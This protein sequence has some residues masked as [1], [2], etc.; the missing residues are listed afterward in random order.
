MQKNIK[1]IFLVATIL[2][3]LA[4]VTAISASE[5]SDDTT[6]LS[7]VDNT[8]ASDVTTTTTV[9]DNKVMDTTKNIKTEEQATDYYVSDTSGSDDNSGTNDSPFKTIQTAL[10]KTS[11]D[12]TYNIHILEGTYK[13][14]GNTNLTVNGN[15]NINF[16]GD[17]IN[18]TVVDGEVQYTI[19][20]A[21]VWG[22]DSYWDYY[23]LISGNWGMN[24]SEG[25]GHITLSNM[26]FQHMLTT[27]FGD[28]L[29]QNN[30]LGTVTNYGNLSVDN[31]FFYQNLGGL[32]AGIQNKAGATLYV[33][34]SIFQE[35]RKSSGTGNF[36]AGIYN[37]GTAL[38]ENSQFIKNA[39]RWG[40]ITNDH[41]I[42][43][44]N[45]RDGISYDLASTFKFGSGIASNTGDADYYNLYDI[46]GILT[47][48]NNTHFENNGMSD[49]YISIGNLTVKNSVFNYSTG[50]TINPLA[51]QSNNQITTNIIN[52]TMENMRA[53]TYS[54]SLSQST[55][56][57]RGIYSNGA[58]ALI[59][60]NTISMEGDSYSIYLGY[61]SQYNIIED[62]VLNSKVYIDG[63][64]NNIITRNNITTKDKSTI[65]LDSMNCTITNNILNA[66]IFKGDKSIET[67]PYLPAEYNIIENNLPTSP[68]DIELNDETYLNIFN[69]DGTIKTNITNGTLIKIVGDVNNKNM[70]LD[71]I[72]VG[73]E[74]VSGKLNNV[75]ITVK[76]NANTIL[77]TLTINNTNSNSYAVLFESEN[78]LITNSKININTTNPISVI[79]IKSDSNKVIKNTFTVYGPNTNTTGFADT[80][81]ADIQSSKN[82]LRDNTYTIFNSTVDDESYIIGIKI[83]KDNTRLT[84]NIISDARINFQQTSFIQVYVENS[85]NNSI[86][87]NNGQS[88]IV[89]SSGIGYYL[90]DSD[91]NIIG[92]PC[93][94]RGNEVKDAYGIIIEGKNRVANSNTIRLTTQTI[95]QGKNSTAI[96]IIN[97]NNTLLSSASSGSTVAGINGSA[98]EINKCNNTKISYINIWDW[99]ITDDT[100]SII[101]ITNSE[102]T[103]LTNMKSGHKTGAFAY[104]ENSTNTTIGDEENLES[105]MI[106][107]KDT[108]I[109]IKNSTQTNIQ[110]IKA[111]VNNSVAIELENSNNNIITNNYLQAQNNYSDNAVHQSD[112]LV[113]EIRD[114]RPDYV[115]LTDENYVKYF[116]DGVYNR[117][118]QPI[119]EVAS[120]INNKTLTFNNPNTVIYSQNNYTINGGII[121]FT[122]EATGSNLTNITTNNSQIKIEAMKS[123]IINIK[124]IDTPIRIEEDNIVVQ[125]SNITSATDKLEIIIEDARSVTLSDNRIIAEN[126][127]KKDP[128]T[129]IN[130]QATIRNNYILTNDTQNIIGITNINSTL[131]TKNNNPIP[132][133]TDENYNKF[134]DENGIYTITGLNKIYL[135]SDIYNK[136]MTFKTDIRLENPH[137]Y[138]IYHTTISNLDEGILTL[139][140]VII[141][142]TNYSYSTIISRSCINLLDDN[143]YGSGDNQKIIV[144]EK[145]EYA[146][147]ISRNNITFDGNNNIIISC[148]NITTS[149]FRY[150][151]IICNGSNITALNYDSTLII[152]WYDDEI[153]EMINEQI[154]ATI[155]FNNITLYTDTP[156]TAIVLENFAGSFFNNE[157]IIN[158]NNGETPIINT[159]NS[160]ETNIY[161]NYIESLDLCGNDAITTD[162][163]KYNNK[164]TS[165]EFKSQLTNITIPEIITV[166]YD[167][168]LNIIPTDAFGREITGTITVTDGEVTIISEN[169]NITYRPTNTGEKT[170][171]IT[172]TDSN[173]K[174]N[175]TTTTVD[176][177]VESPTLIVDSITTT[178]GETISITARITADDETITSINKGKITFKVNGKTLKD[179]NGKVIYAKVVNGT[180]TIENYLVPDD[181][182][183]EGT[184]IQAVYSGSTQCEKLTSE[185][186]EIT[187]EKAAPTLETESITAAAG[188]TIQLKATITDGDKVINTGKVV[189]KINGKTVK[190]ENGKVIY[191]KVVNNQVIVNYTLPADMKAKEYNITA[192]FI[193]SD[194]ERL[195]DT[196]TL[197]VTA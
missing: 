153:E 25:T 76:E 122:S 58:P 27:V 135:G 196:K 172:Y 36:G 3:L 101:K 21:S 72:K 97:A 142:N 138:T 130:S 120:D 11:S 69:E 44:N 41:I 173:G 54:N 103:E 184:T 191:A 28:L 148:N 24:I 182:A 57:A 86:L 34:N 40:T 45:C 32:G 47:I 31:V 49:V 33:N 166:N 119:I 178:A 91:N 146:P 55:G 82:T 197:T 159:S 181:W 147:E 133:L 78:N 110:G 95:V 167:N 176:I 170:L 93:W 84:N 6:V 46:K 65:F 38:I 70:T 136:N 80:I 92:S 85:D 17:G 14:I 109:I 165:T 128:I 115:K 169:T 77:D 123:N 5:V 98:I 114:N 195:E 10:D 175:T 116:T 53:S 66:L 23:N 140:G 19:E 94:V 152:E 2:I 160:T 9:N 59:K 74:R 180:A 64:L 112:E 171:T 155:M 154:P 16:I 193:S 12:G 158:T 61:N 56:S 7:D 87:N 134:F 62:N 129:I 37:N 75:S 192:T 126:Q 151:N 174:Y 183:K 177:T 90:V 121:K 132:E 29:M 22:Q 30:F 81:I 131:Y 48:I 187:V 186:T 137:N 106:E 111:I 79:S 149:G 67:N 89:N 118:I 127:K 113:N 107:T 179:T 194:Y 163:T 100:S 125:N 68:D 188:T 150:N 162:G 156:T 18:K 108:A 35:N 161:N 60:N 190:D 124:A 117:A 144:F 168:T 139:K 1:S 4:G 141:N 26:N 88:Y 164:P 42:T 105:V 143:I 99:T 51:P 63:S 13:G 83:Q 20:G 102:N 157:I 96:K 50:I 71:N 8:V 52:N 39:A 189:F 73:F 15:Y 185:K 43:V 145:S 104:I